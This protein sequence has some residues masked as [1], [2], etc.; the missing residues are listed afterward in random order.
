MASSSSANVADPVAYVTQGLPFGASP[1]SLV[2]SHWSNLGVP[3][4][5]IRAGWGH[6][7]QTRLRPASSIVLVPRLNRRQPIVS[8]PPSS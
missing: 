4:G 6:L 1:S 3:E 5:Q 2:G 8:T 7:F